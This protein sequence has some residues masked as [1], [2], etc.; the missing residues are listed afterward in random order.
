M[1]TMLIRQWIGMVGIDPGMDHL[2]DCRLID[3]I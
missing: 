3:V 1:Q 2:N